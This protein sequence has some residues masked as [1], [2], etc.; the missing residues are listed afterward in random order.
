[1]PCCIGGR[2]PQRIWPQWPLYGSRWKPTLLLSPPYRLCF[3][4]KFDNPELLGTLCFLLKH[5]VRIL[6]QIR[7]F[8]ALPDTSVQTKQ[9]NV[10]TMLICLLG[11]IHQ[12]ESEG[13]GFNWK[14]LHRWRIC[15]IRS[16]EREIWST[17]H[18]FLSVFT[19]LALHYWEHLPAEH[20]IFEVL[21]SPPDSR[22]L[23]SK[24]LHFLMTV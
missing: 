4:S 9:N 15:I 3:F 11:Q 14:F 17:S 6:N 21:K 7:S 5:S 12:L 19:S 22:H 2:R 18:A 13:L 8:L 16:A 24:I 10:L 23:I 1:V 20:E